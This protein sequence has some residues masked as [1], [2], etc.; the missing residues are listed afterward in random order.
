MTTPDHPDQAAK[1][2]RRRRREDLVRPLTKALAGALFVIC[3]LT[4][5]VVELNDRQNDIA[6]VAQTANTAATEA[7]DA[8][9]R[10]SLT[11]EELNNA[12]CAWRGELEDRA[13]RDQRQIDQTD[14]ILRENPRALAGIPPKLIRQSLADRR[15]ALVNLRKTIKTFAAVD[16]TA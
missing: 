15:K 13:D 10:T 1:D 16:C 11:A 3:V 2:K 7:K 8:S 6:E 12:I 5:A 9:A 4:Y 14:R